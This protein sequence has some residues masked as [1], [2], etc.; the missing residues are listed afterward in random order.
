LELKVQKL[1]RFALFFALVI[2]ASAVAEAQGYKPSPYK[3][4]PAFTNIPELAQVF[5]FTPFYAKTPNH[6]VKI[7]VFDNGFYQYQSAIGTNLPNDL[8]YVKLPV[9]DDCDDL[10]V[11]PRKAE[12]CEDH[13]KYMAEM[14][15]GMMTNNNQFLQFTPELY[16]YNVGGI[17]NFK[18]AINDAIQKHIDIILFSVVK[19][20]GGNFDGRGVWNTQINRATSAGIVWVNAAGNYAT[21]T[22]NHSIVSSDNELV[23]L[24]DPRHT[25]GFHCNAPQCHI[26]INLTWSDFK[27][28][29]RLGTDE[30]LDLELLNNVFTLQASSEQHQVL[31]PK[32]V[33]KGNGN[34]YSPSES[35]VADVTQG[36]YYLQVKVKSPKTFK[37]SDT[38][39]ITLDGGQLDHDDDSENILSPAD[40]P[41]VV[42]VGDTDSESS[43]VSKRL[44]KPELIGNSRINYANG[45]IYEG[46]SNTAAFVAAGFGML[47][48]LAPLL[49]RG[50]L[51]AYTAAPTNDV[52]F[53]NKAPQ[54]KS[55]YFMT[56]FWMPRID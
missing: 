48:S 7:A 9:S 45:R 11:D 52:A 49:N 22:Y 29:D 6:R 16:L 37:S 39:R 31:D 55:S 51:L 18:A 46:N 10:K 1:K 34:S 4:A 27:D 36:Q 20:L 30:D 35:I 44:R 41:N 17:T 13:G 50:A 32:L 15:Q 42:T 26:E 12:A 24:P 2:L 56:N 47:K 28:E 3:G 14:V 21:N 19:E 33:A 23:D 40:N 38:L 25:L 8:F 53:P 43:S 54:Q 5:R